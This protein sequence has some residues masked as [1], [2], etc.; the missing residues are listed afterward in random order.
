MNKPFKLKPIYKDYMWG[1]QKMI[2]DLHKR[3]N[4]NPCAEAWEFS[5][6]DAG[7]SYCDSG[8]YKG[9]TIKEIF[10]LHPEYLGKYVNPNGTAP[11]LIKIIDAKDDLSI[12]VH[13]DDDYALKNENSMG[14]SEVW[15]I[16]DSD[17]GH[18]NIGF[19]E[20]VNKETIQ[21]AL[22]NG[23]ISNY[24]NHFSVTKGELY[25]INAGT[26]HSIC[27]GCLLIE[28]QENSDLTY[29]L[30]DYNRVDNNGNKRPLHIDKALDVLNYN[31]YNKPAQNNVGYSCKY[32]SLST[33]FSPLN[34]NTSKDS[35][36]VLI[37]IEGC[38]SIFYDN[39]Q[40]VLQYGESIFI[41]S[42]SSIKVDGQASFL[43]VD[44]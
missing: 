21:N 24:M 27:S 42:D 19:K 37:C 17:N 32:F 28:V 2:T 15:Y 22:A 9:K 36:V 1:G 43:R 14:K 20:N 34:I 12:Q 39:E 29:R 41:P 38:C 30:F 8:E 16:L 3:T 40:I 5:C 35:F 18:L 11:I 7:V 23:D 25:P 10:Q 4:I 26:L 6:H 44:V 13:P 33:I 31:K